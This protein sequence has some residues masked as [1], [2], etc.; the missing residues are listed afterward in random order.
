MINQ[1]DDVRKDLDEVLERH[2]HTL[3]E[4]RPQSV[5]KR[6]DRGYRMPRENIDQ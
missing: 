5:Q 4:N 2:A 1:P 6:Y 3:D